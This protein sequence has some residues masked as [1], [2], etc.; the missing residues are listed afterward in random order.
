MAKRKKKPIRE[1]ISVLL[2]KSNPLTAEEIYDQIIEQ[3]LYTFPAKDPQ[4]VVRSTLRRH[5]VNF[6]FPSGR[7]TKYFSR[8]DEGRFSV[9]PKPV[10]IEPNAFK[11]KPTG[12]RTSDRIISVPI[13]EESGNDGDSTLHTEI[14]WRLLSL[15]SRLGMQVWA[16][17]NDRGRKWNGNRIGDIP[18]LLDELP[19]QFQPA[20]MRIVE[21]IDVIWL[22]QRSFFAAFEVEHSTPIYSGLLRMADLMTLVPNQDIQWYIVS[23]EDRFDKFSRQVI[24]PV[25]QEALKQPLHTVCRFVPYAQLLKRL[26]EA[27]NLLDDLKPSFIERISEKYNPE[28]AFARD[29]S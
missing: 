12:R 28:E 16:P 7:R 23:S 20:A 22:E 18:G 13:E 3:E 14:Q 1:V 21:Y 4:H 6:D 26:E 17:K 10:V 29:D 8:D 9:L 19:A 25:F 2:K 27:K 24:R 15:G 5:C 11:V